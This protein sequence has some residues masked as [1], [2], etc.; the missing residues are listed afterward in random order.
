MLKQNEH[1]SELNMSFGIFKGIT[2]SKGTSFFSSSLLSS[3]FN[4][5]LELSIFDKIRLLSIS[6]L[7][8][9]ILLEISFSLFSLIFISF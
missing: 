7:S 3:L 2:G 6:S 4:S 1:T 5:F 8:S 9:S